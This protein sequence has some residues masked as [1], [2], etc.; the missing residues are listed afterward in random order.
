M[1]HSFYPTILKESTPDV[2]YVVLSSQFDKC[3]LEEH[4]NLSIMDFFF[5]SRRQLV[6]TLF[7]FCQYP[8][9]RYHFSLVLVGPHSPCPTNSDHFFWHRV[10]LWHRL[11]QQLNSRLL[12]ECSSRIFP[13]IASCL[14]EEAISLYLYILQLKR[15]KTEM[16]SGY[17]THTVKETFISTKWE[18]RMRRKER[19]LTIF[20]GPMGLTEH[21]ADCSPGP[22]LGSQWNSVPAWDCLNCFATLKTFSLF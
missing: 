19:S 21:L 10:G 15:G 13:E 3:L 18:F 16:A 12:K 20:L 11:S 9:F 2:L 5:S 6:D 1:R 4:Y 7:L 17:L 8:I 14:L 22:L